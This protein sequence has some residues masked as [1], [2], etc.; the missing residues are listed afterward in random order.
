MEIEDHLEI[1]SK[2]PWKA[3]WLIRIKPNL[4]SLDALMDAEA[5]EKFQEGWREADE[6]R[7]SA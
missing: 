3:G 5:Y 7:A 6:T 2:D 4:K 1:L